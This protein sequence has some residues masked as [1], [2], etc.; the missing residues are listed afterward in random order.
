MDDRDRDQRDYLLLQHEGLDAEFVD[1]DTHTSPSFLGPLGRV[2]IFVGA[3]SSGKSRLLRGLARRSDHVLATRGEANGIDA[4]LAALA[5]HGARPEAKAVLTHNPYQN[6]QQ[7]AIHQSTFIQAEKALRTSVGRKEDANGGLHQIGLLAETYRTPPR[8][9][10]VVTRHEAT[11]ID[12]NDMR[13]C[14]DLGARVSKFMRVTPQRLL[15]PTLRSAQTL[16]DQDGRVHEDIFGR[17]FKR[18]YPEVG[19]VT[20]WTGATIYEDLLKLQCA[21]RSERGKKVVFERFLSRTLFNGLSVELVAVLAASSPNSGEKPFDSHINFFV[22]GTAEDRELYN[23]GDGIGA[24][25][26][27]LYPLFTAEKGTWAFIE[28]PEVHLHPAYQRIFVEALLHDPDLR[29]RDLRV[30]LTTHSN[31]L[32]DVA[33]EYP[34]DVA[35]FSLVDEGEKK[36]IRRA[37]TRD[38]R[39]LDALGVRNGSVY[40]ANCTI[41]VE[42]PSDVTYLRAYLD[43]A[44]QEKYGN[45]RPYQEDLH[46]AFLE[47]GGGLLANYGFRDEAEEGADDDAERLDAA[48]IANRICI[49]ADHDANKEKKHQAWEARAAKSNGALKYVKTTGREIENELSA[50][51]LKEVVMRRLKERDLTLDFKSIRADRYLG[52]GLAKLFKGHPLEA[53]VANWEDDSGTLTKYWKGRFASETSM[54]LRAAVEAAA[55]EA[56]DD[57]PRPTVKLVGARE[58]ALATSVLDF[59][60]LHNPTRPTS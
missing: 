53:K 29:K 17:T 16:W 38:I 32:L 58:R 6:P 23:V 24:I 44:M 56:S 19:A 9:N 43:V 36:A 40:L 52:T 49:V 41:W 21:P 50:D 37:Q 57:N 10:V 30:F 18:R 2:N 11:N 55:K 13:A 54:V 45:T 47:Y 51:L 25:T 42:G 33:M 1:A 60:V 39:V 3:N 4:A 35:V 7:L 5:R 15:I 14:L 59:I 22:D 20:L 31:H 26:I 28:E 27:L 34:D 8:P 12:A 48:V 46:F